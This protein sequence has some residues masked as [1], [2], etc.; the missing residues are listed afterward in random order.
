MKPADN[1]PVVYA[2]IVDVA[3][4]VNALRPGTSRT[5]HDYGNDAFL[6]YVRRQIEEVKTIDIVWDVYIENSLKKTTRC[7]R[8]KGVRRRVPDSSKIPGDWQSIFRL[9]DN[10]NGTF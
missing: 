7:R 1:S 5:F 2:L 9:E 6:P 8:G 10:K 3:V 4:V